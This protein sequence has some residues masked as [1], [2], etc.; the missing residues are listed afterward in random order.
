MRKRRRQGNS[1]PQKTKNSA[2]DLV[3]N[4]DN[5]YPVPDPNRMMRTTISEQNDAHKNI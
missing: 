3:E 1:I 4:E 2:E 5:K